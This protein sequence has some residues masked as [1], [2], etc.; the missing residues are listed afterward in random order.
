[1]G[2]VIVNIS[3]FY[4]NLNLCKYIYLS[5]KCSMRCHVER[6]YATGCHLQCFIRK[7]YLPSFRR[8]PC[9]FPQQKQL[10]PPLLTERF[11]TVRCVESK[12]IQMISIK[13][14]STN[15]TTCN[16]LAPFQ[17]VSKRGNRILEFSGALNI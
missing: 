15:N 9:K 2:S 6:V 10:P 5:S 1:M 8:Y 4:Q 16:K 14:P 12:L 7:C 17:N 11:K 3:T 13:Q